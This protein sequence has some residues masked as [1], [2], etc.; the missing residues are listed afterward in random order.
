ML[1]FLKK[2]ALFATLTIAIGI[3]LFSSAYAVANPEDLIPKPNTETN[4]SDGDKQSIIEN[5][6]KNYETLPDVT[7]QGLFRTVIKTIMYLSGILA[8]V[9]MIIAGIMFLGSSTNEE[10]LVKA[11]KVLIY[12]V[13]G[14]VII[15]VSYAVV[16]G[17]LK[18]K[19]VQ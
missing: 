3:P 19:L 6:I 11:R 8:T 12:V 7:Y 1:K 4:E 2:I 17:I 16:T 15:S 14:I 13:V 5:N 10:N 18:I 9:G